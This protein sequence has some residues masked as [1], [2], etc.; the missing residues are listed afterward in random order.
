MRG[1][2]WLVERTL[3]FSRRTLLHGVI[4]I[5]I[6]THTHQHVRRMDEVR[7]PRAILK[8]Q[9]AGRRGKRRPLKRLLDGWRRPE[10]ARRPNSLTALWWWYIHMCVC[11]FLSSR[12]CLPF[13]H[14]LIPKSREIH[15]RAAGCRPLVYQTSS[16]S[17]WIVAVFAPREVRI[18]MHKRWSLR[19]IWP[20][21]FPFSVRNLITSNNKTKWET[22]TPLL[23]SEVPLWP[24]SK[25]RNI[26]SS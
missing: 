14:W 22:N 2:S 19:D 11:V 24:D 5:Y 8:Y 20:E 15:M 21:T 12:K 16:N 23:L 4:Y 17:L 26:S 7:L 10:Q 9:P 6:H 13:S 25:I 1:I 18:S 3:R